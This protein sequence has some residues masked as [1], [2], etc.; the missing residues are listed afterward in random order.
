MKKGLIQKN[1]YHTSLECHPSTDAQNGHE[2]LVIRIHIRALVS[3]QVEMGR[4]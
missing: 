3:P 2:K 1:S 4:S